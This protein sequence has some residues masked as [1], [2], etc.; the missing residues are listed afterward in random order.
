MQNI[1]SCMFLAAIDKKTLLL[2][3][4]LAKGFHRKELFKTKVI[5]K[6]EQETFN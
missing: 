2:Y 6:L 3:R 1:K 5:V 4:L